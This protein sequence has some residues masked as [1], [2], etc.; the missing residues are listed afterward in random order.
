VRVKQKAPPPRRAGER[1]LLRDAA[2]LVTHRKHGGVNADHEC[3]TQRRE[4][5]S[6]HLSM[7][8]LATN[9]LWSVRAALTMRG[10]LRSTSAFFSSTD[11]KPLMARMTLGLRGR[12]VDLLLFMFGLVWLGCACQHTNSMGHV[13]QAVVHCVH[14]ACVA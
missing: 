7:L 11:C 10:F 13:M 2:R 12:R 8:T 5:Q 3:D 4:H 1:L 6:T 14:I 9:S